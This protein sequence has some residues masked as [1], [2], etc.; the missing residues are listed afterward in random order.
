MNKVLLM[1]LPIQ[2]YLQKEFTNDSGYNPSLGLLSIGTWMELNGYEPIVLDLC[3]NRKTSKELLQLIE[4]ENPIL[5]GMSV[6]TENV[7]MAI[8]TAK[9]IKAAFPS[10]KIV[11]GGAHPTLVP[12]DI[13][14]SQY[15]DFI[16]RKE[17]ESTF[18]EL[19]E[20]VVSNENI[21]KFDDIA[22]L[23]FKRDNKVIQNK[24]RSFITD[25]D[26]MPLPKRE[27][28]GIENYKDIINISTSRG[29]PGNCIY[30]SATALSGATYRTRN[31]DNVFL[32]VVLLR[33]IVRDSFLK[34]YIVDDTFT[35]VPV[36]VLRFADL[37]KKYN[38]NIYW[39]CESRVDVM[40]EELLDAMTSS[41]CI[42]VQYGIESGSQEV[43]DK[44]RK[45]INLDIARKVIDS[46]FKRKILPCLSFMVGHFCDT[47][48]TMEETLNF[49]K[50]VSTNYKA[51][52]A[53]S[54]NTPFPGTWQYT[55][56]DKLG[57]KLVTDKYK[58]FSLLDPIV[59]TNAFTTN[60]QREIFFEARQYLAR[61]TSIERM[62]KEMVD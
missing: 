17:G 35:A 6:Y 22:G 15:V 20:A 2:S 13:I 28:A 31:I 8:S 46:T 43:L 18:L 45:G 34:I 37:I 30:C 52:V 60:D 27:L 21:I 12:D 38:L 56:K 61:I 14:T 9:I 62:R 44:I 58:L 19:C 29:C 47:K 59:E 41:R 39:H 1:N 36:R 4:E 49:I 3:Y 57:M 7:D 48:E 25:L 54:F 5:I 16:I 26:I 11:F 10:I 33:V 55:H 42:A 24:L 50:H 51:E 23:V 32:E 53:L 40:T